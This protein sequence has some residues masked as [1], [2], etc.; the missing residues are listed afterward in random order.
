MAVV[1]SV[2][3]EVEQFKRPF[4]WG[5]LIVGDPSAKAVPELPPGETLSH[6][7]ELIVIPVRH[8]QDIDDFDG[9][10]FEVEV[11]CRRRT[12]GFA[13]G[14]HHALLHLSSGDLGVGDVNRETVLHPGPGWWW[15]T[16]T[17]RP[18][19]HAES[20]D[21]EFSKAEGCPACRWPGL[22]EEPWA[23]NSPSQ[24]ICP[25]CGTQFGYDDAIGLSEP[26]SLFRRHEELRE[27]W[28]NGGMN[29][30]SDSREPPEGWNPG[31]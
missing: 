21:I 3:P 24:E 28:V 26:G 22:M 8:A 14:Q 15:V 2:G 9:P 11:T 10:P 6:S 7:S 29:W 17:M 5:V 13:T 30:W 16:I 27:A 12:A 23:G 31:E 25:S 1:T 20:V 19:V 4:N 18:E